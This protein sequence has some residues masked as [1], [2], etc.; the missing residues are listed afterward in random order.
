MIFYFTGTGNSRYVAERLSRRDT[1]VSIGESLRK[2]RYE[3]DAGD[4]PSV[5]FVVPVYFFGVPSVVLEFVSRLKLT[6]ASGAY[7]YTVLTCG[8]KTGAAGRMLC[9]ALGKIGITVDATYSVLFPS[10]YIPL[11]AAPK[12]GEVSR[13]QQRASVSLISLKDSIAARESGEHDVL[14]GIMPSVM[15]ALLYPLYGI[16][17]KTEKFSVTARCTGCGACVRMCPECAIEMREGRPVWVKSHCSLCV[18]CLN[19]CPRG[20]I[21]LGKRTSGRRRYVNPAVRF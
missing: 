8:G 18:A 16:S 15:T 19:R 3:F 13:I 21:E 9:G 11:K 2:D 1:V 6:K 10:N 5:G 12:P 4:E 14:R 20:A 7:V 17:R